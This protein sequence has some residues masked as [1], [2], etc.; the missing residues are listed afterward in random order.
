[1]ACAR[2]IPIMRYGVFALLIL[3]TLSATGTYVWGK[4]ASEPFERNSS[5]SVAK[6][7]VSV[8]GGTETVNMVAGGAMQTYDLTVT[9]NSDVASEYSIKVSNIPAGVKVGLDIQSEADLMEPTAGEV[10]FT[11]TGDVLG[12]AAPNNSRPH[13]LT[14]QADL[15]DA[16]ATT[17]DGV[18]LDIDVVFT[19]Q[20]PQS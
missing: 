18:E 13:T 1:M 17:G 11:N 7:D 12:F 6:W 4:M 9:N 19:Q 20:E 14:L 15:D 16:A 8:T 5:M 2:R 10:T 3:G